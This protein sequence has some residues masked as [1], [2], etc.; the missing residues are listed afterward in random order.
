MKKAT[1]LVLGVLALGG[2]VR[3]LH[4][5]DHADGPAASA[6]PAADITDVFAWTSADARRVHLVMDLVR[7]ATPQSRF[8]DGVQYVF[9]TTSR[10]AFG[11]APSPEI[12][13]ICIFD[14]VQAIQC[15]VGDRAY[16]SGDARDPAGL[17]SA[18][19][20]LRVFAG[21]REDPFFFNLAGFR[22]AARTVAGAAGD[23]AFDAAGCPALDDATST[24]L[25]TQLQ[26]APDGGPAVD[27]F[28][29]F[30][31]L[32]IAV[33]VDSSLLTDGGPIV[34]V[35]GSTNRR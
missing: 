22:A 32:A 20:R 31:V 4:A 17:T 15:W 33:A 8:S 9:H 5:A 3:P 1:L 23:L 7:N 26:I 21:L 6:D 11:A 12:D 13:V 10:A 35:W 24:A 28:A 27:G 18:D 19:G 2:I 14:A 34:G 16:V 25:V 29:G 30:D